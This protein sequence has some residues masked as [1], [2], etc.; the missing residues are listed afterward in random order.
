MLKNIPYPLFKSGL[1]LSSLGLIFLFGFSRNLIAN[2]RVTV[3]E[4][5]SQ[6]V[7]NCKV[8]AKVQMLSLLDV[9][10]KLDGRSQVI[11]NLNDQNKKILLDSNLQNQYKNIF[12]NCI[13]S[14]YNNI[15]SVRIGNMEKTYKKYLDNYKIHQGYVKGFTDSIHNQDLIKRYE[16]IFN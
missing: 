12:K 2:E 4:L 14:N 8:Y 11:N 1:V 13:R 6:A 9:S 10:I 15:N 7:T 16:D 3:A 5:Q